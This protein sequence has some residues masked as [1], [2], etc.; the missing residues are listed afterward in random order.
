MLKPAR[1]T[2]LRGRVALGMKGLAL[3]IQQTALALGGFA[4]GRTGGGYEAG[5]RD[6]RRTRGWRPGEGSPA[7]DILPGL[8]IL[9]G[10]SRDLERN[11][12]LALG[13]IQTKANGVIGT[14][15]VLRST[16]DAEVLGVPVEQ[17]AD[18]QYQIEREWEIFEREADFTGQM[19]LRDMQRLMYRSAQVSGDIGIARRYRK[20]PGET[21]GTRIVLLEADRI[22]NPNRQ[23]DTDLIQGGVQVSAEGEVLGCYVSDRHP[24]ELRGRA[25]RWTYVPRRGPSGMVQFVLLPSEIVRPGQVRG[26]PLFAPVEETLKQLGDY[27]DA[28]VKAAIN[29]AYLFAFEKPAT[30]VDD[31]GS[32]IITRPDGETDDAGELTLEDLTITTLDPGSDMTVKKPERPNTAFDGF[33]SAFCKYLGVGL[34]LPYEVLM[35]HFGASFSASRGALEVAWKGFHRRPGEVHPL[36]ARPDSRVAVHRDGGGRP[37]RRAGLLRRPDQAGGVARPRVG[38]TDADPDQPAGRGQFG[39]DRPR[40]RGEEPRAG[41]DRAHGRRLRH[42][43]QADPARAGGAGQRHAAAT[44][45]Q[46]PKDCRPAAKRRHKRQLR[47]AWTIPG[48]RGSQM[49]QRWWRRICANA[50]RAA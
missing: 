11:H 22:S 18:L 32:P 50:S 23:T 4:S 39:Q 21:Y 34:N 10:R 19:H 31:D 37:L 16:I 36:R 48:S 7:A 20:R 30:P 41:D 1:K 14:G 17:I 3:G 47:A 6:S 40:I 24:G 12:P 27:T 2:S 44:A 33:V 45:G 9:R 25:L 28:E 46:R 5:R 42:Q 35:M 8:E 13:A 49:N 15:L 29:D 38:G 43:E 26:V